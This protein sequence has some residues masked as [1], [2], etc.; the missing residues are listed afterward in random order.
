MI[1]L[2]VNQ[3][4]TTPSRR[5]K[6][7]LAM[8][9]MSSQRQTGMVHYAR[10]AGWIVDSSLPLYHA[11]GEELDYLDTAQYDGVLALCSRASP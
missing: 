7:L 4:K 10:E 3:P 1:A 8:G 9:F 2:A 5:R 6:V 11:V